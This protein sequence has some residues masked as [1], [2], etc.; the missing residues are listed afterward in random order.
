MITSKKKRSYV[1]SDL[2]LYMSSVMEKHWM[3]QAPFINIKEI[4]NTSLFP[5]KEAVYN[6][7]HT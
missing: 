2:K 1:K 7:C 3:M 4:Q 6:V 5:I